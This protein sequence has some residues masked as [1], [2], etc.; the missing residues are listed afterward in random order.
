MQHGTIGRTGPKM[1]TPF[2]HVGGEV[3]REAGAE[4][5]A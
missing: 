2:A 1:T 5:K 3:E 4:A